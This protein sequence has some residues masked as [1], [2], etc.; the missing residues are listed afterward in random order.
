MNQRM[1]S[2]WQLALITMAGA[3]ILAVG[4][5]G[6]GVLGIVC[7][8]IVLVTVPFTWRSQRRTG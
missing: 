1:V 2:G 4:I 6:G 5:A 3:V 7:G 8:S